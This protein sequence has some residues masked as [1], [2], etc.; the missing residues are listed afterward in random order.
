MVLT[1]SEVYFTN[2]DTVNVKLLFLSLSVY[3]WYKSDLGYT[4]LLVF[5]YVDL[6]LVHVIHY[7][8]L[9]TFSVFV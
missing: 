6:I 8:V 3:H 5:S 4:L 2:F 9:Q 7:V 1:T